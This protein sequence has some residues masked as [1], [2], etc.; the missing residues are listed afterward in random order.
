MKF[1]D[2]QHCTFKLKS[3]KEFT[4]INW[5][6]GTSTELFIYPPESDFSTRDFGFRLSIATVTTEDSKFSYLP[7]IHRVL[8]LLDGAFTLSHTHYHTKTLVPFDQDTFEGGWET[9]CKG[10]GKDFNLM[11][12]S[13][14]KG[15]LEV[16]ENDIIKV[17]SD[18]ILI[19]S[20]EELSFADDVKL[21]K[22]SLLIIEN[23][24]FKEQNQCLSL[25]GKHIIV[26]IER[27]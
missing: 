6:G 1:K 20:L 23:Q 24:T 15:R 10:T 17:D 13:P 27:K 16:S 7:N 2:A 18:F 22:D 4:T 19:Y 14:Y 5:S 11:F 12:K 9:H 21:H 8:L 25:K 26:R 3:A